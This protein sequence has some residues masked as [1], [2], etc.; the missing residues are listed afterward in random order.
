MASIKTL[1]TATAWLDRPVGSV[2]SKRFAWFGRSSLS[3]VGEQLG[4]DAR[5]CADID[6]C[7]LRCATAVGVTRGVVYKVAITLTSPR[8][9][10]G[11]LLS[12]VANCIEQHLG[13]HPTTGIDGLLAFDAADGNVVV[14]EMSDSASPQVVVYVTSTAATTLPPAR[15]AS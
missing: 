13:T 5:A 14:Q 15:A 8:S 3:R 12:T 10:P 4:E 1:C 11:E 2:P 7:G 9:V 6:W